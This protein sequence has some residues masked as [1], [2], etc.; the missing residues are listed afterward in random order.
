MLWGCGAAPS[1]GCWGAAQLHSRCLLLARAPCCC[2]GPC[3]R[4]THH[5]PLSTTAPA[6]P[7]GGKVG[8]L[9]ALRAQL[10]ERLAA[11][12]QPT[13]SKKFFTGGVSAVAAAATAAKAAAPAAGDEEGEV[14]G[15]AVGS[16]AT[17]AL[18]PPAQPSLHH[19]HHQ[20]HQ[21]PP[22][23]ARPVPV[24]AVNQTIQLAARLQQSKQA[25]AQGNG[26]RRARAAAARAAAQQQRH[27][28]GSLLV[29]RNQLKKRAGKGLVVIPGAFGRDAQGPNALDAL[30]QRLAA[31]G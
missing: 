31:L 17:P 29:S 21:P 7:A 8:E 4:H 9:A 13:I 24:E 19:H 1:S 10:A 20:G 14:R 22:P 5:P 11:P 23:Q 16:L 6:A 12:L 3:R 30:K 26:S 2:A 15:P 27:K 25:A 18:L 28:A